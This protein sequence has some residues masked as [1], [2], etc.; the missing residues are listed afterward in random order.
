MTDLVGII[1]NGAP[2]NEQISSLETQAEFLLK[3]LKGDLAANVDVV[4]R[5]YKDKIE[6]F[7]KVTQDLSGNIDNSESV[8]EIRSGSLANRISK[9]KANTLKLNDVIKACEY[10][11]QI[12]NDLKDVPSD[13][14]SR[15]QLFVKIKQM[16]G[17][18]DNSKMENLKL[19]KGYILKLRKINPCT[20]INVK[21]LDMVKITESEIVIQNGIKEVAEAA[22]IIEKIGFFQDKIYDSLCEFISSDFALAHE[23]GISI[24]LD[25]KTTRANGHILSSLEN[26]RKFLFHLKS[27]G[28]EPAERHSVKV[29]EGLMYSFLHKAM[30][31]DQKEAGSIKKLIA[32]V[33]EMQPVLNIE[34]LSVHKFKND[35]GK[36]IQKSKIAKCL[37]S[38]RR[39]IVDQNESHFDEVTPISTVAEVK[40]EI[41]LYDNRPVDKKAKSLKFQDTEYPISSRCQKIWN[42]IQENPEAARLV[43]TLYFTIMTTSYQLKFETCFAAAFIYHSDIQFLIGGLSLLTS[44]G[45]FDEMEKLKMVA[46]VP[47]MQLSARSVLHGHLSQIK[48]KIATEIA[49]VLPKITKMEN[50]F[51]YDEVAK[52]FQKCVLTVNT[53]LHQ[54]KK[55][56]PDPQ[57]APF[58]TIL[59]NVVAD[60]LFDNL[61]NLEDIPADLCTPIDNLI[62]ICVE[63]PAYDQ[64]KLEDV[65]FM[66]RSSLLEITSNFKNG[67]LQIEASQVRQMIRALFSNTDHRQQ[68]L[69]KIHDVSSSSTRP[70]QSRGL[71]AK[72]LSVS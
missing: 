7:Q 60:L 41:A 25:S 11:I 49:P 22:R 27:C 62:K 1:S 54:M 51:V 2:L 61:V 58:A 32:I 23:S 72:Q 8:R 53:N 3:T 70:Q 31:T 68:A 64:T 33:L 20:E 10:L 55:Y 37:E 63:L 21:W 39:L 18:L 38:A 46:L 35:L 47:R 67:E 29:L 66:I 30:P 43:A 50:Q 65:R 14:V 44:S 71:G 52:A 26:I 57:V 48:D 24:V 36:L 4:D 5:G 15:A 9:A 34:M 40:T 69:A 56:L 59:T 28:L 45:H 19:I 12:E 42:L 17:E 6:N 13:L 16:L